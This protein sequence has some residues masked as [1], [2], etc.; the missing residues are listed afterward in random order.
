MAKNIK[1]NKVVVALIL[2]CFG[3]IL[4]GYEKKKK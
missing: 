2:V 4:W 1:N 3:I